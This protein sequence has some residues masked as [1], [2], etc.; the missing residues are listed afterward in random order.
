MQPINMMKLV[1]GIDSL[2][3]FIHYQKQDTVL[4]NGKKANT[5]HTRNMPK[6]AEDI[7]TSGGSIYRVIKGSMCCRQQII[8]FES[9]ET[10]AG[11]RT[12][13]YTSPKVIETQPLPQHGFQGWRYLK[14][15]KTPVDLSALNEGTAE[16]T[17]TQEEQALKDLG[18]DV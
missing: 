18:I 5:V 6:Q 16:L 2:E 17:H 4:F 9:L 15:E 12:I 14:P 8:G 3:D 13:I 7:I 1:V 10:D 11:K